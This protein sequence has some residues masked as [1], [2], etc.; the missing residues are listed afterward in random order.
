MPVMQQ[1]EDITSMIVVRLFAKR[2]KMMMSNEDFLMLASFGAA[3]A[4]NIVTVSHKR[5]HLEEVMD[6]EIRKACELMCDPSCGSCHRT[7]IRGKRGSN[8]VICK[9]VNQVFYRGDTVLEL[10]DQY[11]NKYFSGETSLDQLGK[12]KMVQNI[13]AAVMLFIMPRRRLA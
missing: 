3:E 9:C 7:G 4:I 13:T 10:G 1:L 2:K 8:Y 11:S 12:V 6:E 5:K